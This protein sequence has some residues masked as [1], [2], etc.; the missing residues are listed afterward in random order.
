M[1]ETTRA[2]DPRIDGRPSECVRLRIEN[3]EL[4][5][6]LTMLVNSE[7]HERVVQCLW[8]KARALLHTER[9]RDDRDTPDRQQA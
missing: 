7:P 5:H 9:N 6:M 1:T 3:A 8:T 4:R 2:N